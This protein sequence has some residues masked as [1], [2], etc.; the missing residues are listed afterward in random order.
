MNYKTEIIIK[1]HILNPLW[2]PRMERRRKLDHFIHQ[3]LFMMLV[4]HNSHAAEL[5]AK[6]PKIDNDMA[7]DLW[8][9][10][11]DEPYSPELWKAATEN[12]MFQKT[13]YKSES[14]N[15]PAP[16]TIAWHLIFE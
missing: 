5:F 3:L 11:R 2:K 6:M 16:G 4:E 12:A 7:H 14:A 15:S 8:F 1:G 10:H 9:G 13:E